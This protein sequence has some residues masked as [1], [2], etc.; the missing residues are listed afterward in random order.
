MLNYQRVFP[1]LVFILLV[2]A[3]K[4]GYFMQLVI[5]P[6]VLTDSQCIMCIAMLCAIFPYFA[7]WV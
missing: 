3:N 6:I 2:I 1:F 7:I 4:V 5:Y